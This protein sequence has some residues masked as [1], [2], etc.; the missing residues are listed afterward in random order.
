MIYYVVPFLAVLVGSL[1]IYCTRPKQLNTRLILAFSGAYLLAITAFHLL[2]EAFEGGTEEKRIGIFIMTGLLLQII[3]EYLSKGAE[4]GHMNSQTTSRFPFFVFTSLMLH[5]FLEG[6]PLHY[7]PGLVFGIMAHK[8][9]IAMIFTSFLI[10]SPLP[11]ITSITV[12]F[13][14]AISTPLGS[15]VAQ[16]FPI[17]IHYQKEMTALV[18]GIFLHV[19]T[20]IL[21]E[22]NA[23]H[24]FNLKKF[25]VIIIAI[26]TAYFS[27]S[28]H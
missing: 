16:N 19:S 18:I 21:F 4:H 20:T 5:A 26:L 15:F 10:Q 13:L 7:T 12:L 24:T 3:L 25:S 22:S 1:I 2:P 6:F 27:T 8:I 23:G 11:K 9:P 14:F 28:A 17:I